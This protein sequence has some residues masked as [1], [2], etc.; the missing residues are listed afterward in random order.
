M[1]WL[2]LCLFLLSV[3]LIFVSIDKNYGYVKKNV[4][5]FSRYNTRLKEN[6]KGHKLNEVMKSAGIPFSLYHYHLFRICLLSTFG[7]SVAAEWVKTGEFSIIKV[8]LVGIL[9]IIT[10][11]KETLLGRKSPFS[12][13]I[14]SFLENTRRRYNDELYLAVSQ[15]KNSF[16]IR[17]SRP[18]SGQY[19]LEEVMRYTDKTKP[20]FNRFLNYWMAG[21]KDL[22]IE[23]FDK[24]IG[25]KE[26]QSLSQV[27]NK[28]DEIN[29]AEMREQLET[30]QMI[31][32]TERETNKKKRNEVKSLI[33]FALVIATSL[34][35]LLDLLVVG[36]FIDFIDQLQELT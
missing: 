36:F 10:L 8:F 9:Y 11:P 29:P 20:I 23:Y 12:G 13:M 3:F 22:A 26:A 31:Y 7:L 33:L 21:E 27:F 1:E 16:I 5:K 4:R 17:K 2:I 19:I 34:V 32:R 30:Y 18:P 15:M 14:D 6:Y 24:A 35:I 25:T 28:L